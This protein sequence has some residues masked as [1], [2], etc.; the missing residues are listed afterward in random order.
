[1]HACILHGLFVCP[2]FVLWECFWDASEDMR[3]W[4]EKRLD[5]MSPFEK[6]KYLH[7]VGFDL[8]ARGMQQLPV[9]MT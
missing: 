8:L 5:P 4:G 1:M 9:S 2:F 3:L 7:E 6:W